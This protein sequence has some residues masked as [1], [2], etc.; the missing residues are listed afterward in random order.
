MSFVRQFKIQNAKVKITEKIKTFKDSETGKL[1]KTCLKNALIGFA[2]GI[3]TF[4]G[5]FLL[6]KIFRK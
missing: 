4:M 2:T 1:V 6:G 5:G 3:G